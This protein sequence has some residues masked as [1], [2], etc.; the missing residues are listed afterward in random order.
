MVVLTSIRQSP[1]YLYLKSYCLCAIVSLFQ[2]TPVSS[3]LPRIKGGLHLARSPG[4]ARA[5][6]PLTQRNGRRR[7]S[8][9]FTVLQR[10]QRRTL[11]LARIKHL[12]RRDDNDLR[13][14]PE[15]NLDAF[16]RRSSS[17]NTDEKAFI[18]I[19]QDRISCQ[20]NKYL[21]TFLSL[22]EDEIVNPKDVPLIALG[23]SGGGYRAMYG[24][25]SFL[26]VAKKMGLWD[27]LTW[28]AGV[29]GSCWT[30]AGYYTFVGQSTSKLVQHYLSVARELA[31]PLSLHALNTVA[32]SS[33]GIYFLLG[34]LIRKTASPGRDIGLVMMDLYATLTT[35]YQF[36]S[37]QPDRNSVGPPC[38]FQKSGNAQV[39]IPGLS[40]CRSSPP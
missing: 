5:N 27:C 4:Q 19:R 31:H 8:R 10:R 3:Q 36:L 20:G 11:D 2:T 33:Q 1:A 12:L 26:S 22:A 34:P 32:R 13:T 25:A 14:Y 38:S 30:L 40:Q 23:G 9:V 29:S 28:T 37:R 17:L 16:V 24:F 6:T 35:T 15:I 7:L 21:H 18:N 39:L